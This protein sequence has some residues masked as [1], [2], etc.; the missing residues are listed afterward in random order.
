MTM[1]WNRLSVIG[2]VKI[3]IAP[4]YDDSR[5]KVALWNDPQIWMSVV[6]INRY[7]ICVHDRRCLRHECLDYHISR[8]RTSEI[9]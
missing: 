1:M 5:A 4:T 8:L 3:I 2:K 6:Q 9:S 7:Y